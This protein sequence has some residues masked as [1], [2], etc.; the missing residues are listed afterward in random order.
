[1]DPRNEEGANDLSSKSRLRGVRAAS[2]PRL[3]GENKQACCLV[4]GENDSGIASVSGCTTTRLSG[5]SFSRFIAMGCDLTDSFLVMTGSPWVQS[6]LSKVAVPAGLAAM[7]AGFGG[8][9][10]AVIAGIVGK[11][12]LPVVLRWLECVSGARV[13]GTWLWSGSKGS[14]TLSYC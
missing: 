3:R 1:M 4:R 14:S 9:G 8:S 11:F 13:L 2:T 10:I 5:C 12:S 7:K 6:S